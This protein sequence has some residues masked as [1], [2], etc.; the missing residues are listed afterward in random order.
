MIY[1]FRNLRMMNGMG[2]MKPPP[3]QPRNGIE[4]FPGQP[5][6]LGEIWGNPGDTWGNLGHPGATNVETI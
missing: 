1:V 2:R 3:S 6:K 4:I 5:G